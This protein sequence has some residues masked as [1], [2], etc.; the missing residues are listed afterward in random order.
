MELPLDPMMGRAL[1]ASGQ[2]GC[3]EEMLSIAALMQVQGVFGASGGG[4]PSAAADC[5]RSRFTALEGDHLSLLNAYRAFQKVEG[6][7]HAQSWCGRHYLSFRALSRAS[8]IRAQLVKYL[9][10]CRIPLVSCAVHAG[11][12]DESDIPLRKC[13]AA[14]FFSQAARLHADGKYR[15]ARNDTHIL[16]IHPSSIIAT[17]RP[18]KWV[19]YHEEVHTDQ[20]YMRDVTAIEPDWLTE[21]APHFYKYDQVAPKRQRL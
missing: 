12:E 7:R 13:L 18:P 2:F 21:L 16:A 19:V 5:E 3:S 20:H 11:D 9:K 6:A 4:R 15:S 1:L 14:G 10:K 8:E 17:E